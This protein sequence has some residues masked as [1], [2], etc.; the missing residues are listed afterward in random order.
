MAACAGRGRAS[1][2]PGACFTPIFCGKTCIGQAN[3]ERSHSLLLPLLPPRPPRPPRPLPVDPRAPTR[4]HTTLQSKTHRDGQFLGKGSQKTVHAQERNGT[5]VAIIKSQTHDLTME[6]TLVTT[7]AEH[8]P[9]PHVMKLLGLEFGASSRVSM[10]APIALFGSMLELVD[11]LEF[12]GLEI[13]HV[14]KQVVFAQIL[15]AVLHLNGVGIEHGDLAARNILVFNYDPC[16][17]KSTDVRLSD[18]GDARVGQTPA[19]A[20]LR[21]AREL[22]DL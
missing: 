8:A 3:V 10:V 16:D 7:I 14:H 5:M 15:S 19:S 9:H 4:A 20:M 11:G 18:F 12:E 21:L 17:P 2:W 13:S 6:A 22:A 1:D